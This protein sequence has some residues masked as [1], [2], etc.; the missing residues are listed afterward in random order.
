M[1]NSLIVGGVTRLPLLARF[2]LSKAVDRPI[3]FHAG[4]AIDWLLHSEAVTNGRGF[5][6]S[7]HFF[8]G[9]LPGYPET[10]GYIIPTLLVAAQR[11]DRP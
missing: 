5:A 10:S 2:A 4:R 3:A 7:L 9:W 6:H 8:R 11:Y 1:T